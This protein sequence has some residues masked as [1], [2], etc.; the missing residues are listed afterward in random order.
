MANPSSR[1]KA[2]HLDRLNLWYEEELAA[3]KAKGAT[4]DFL[5]EP[6]F[7]DLVLAQ[8][9]KKH[10]DEIRADKELTEG[11]F[12]AL[13]FDKATPAYFRKM[14]TEYREQGYAELAYNCG[15]CADRRERGEI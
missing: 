10:E 9:L 14:A 3:F 12:M 8:V 2:E 7:A 6:A 13:C 15:V 1:F 4:D 5:T 11:L